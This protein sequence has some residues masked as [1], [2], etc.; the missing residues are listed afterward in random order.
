MAAEAAAPQPQ[1]QPTAGN[2]QEDAP[3]SD[4]ALLA[5]AELAD[6]SGPPQSVRTADNANASTGGPPAV[7]VQF[8][9]GTQTFHRTDTQQSGRHVYRARGTLDGKGGLTLAYRESESEES[10]PGFWELGNSSGSC[11]YRLRT[12][13]LTPSELIGTMPWERSVGGGSVNIVM[14]QSVSVESGGWVDPGLLPYG[15]VY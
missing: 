1:S 13:A 15:G 4:E 5:A 8:M 2:V 14:M 11:L 6:H 12:A 7:T 10:A 3:C 9:W